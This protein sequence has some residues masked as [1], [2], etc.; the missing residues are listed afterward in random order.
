[1]YHTTGWLQYGIDPIYLKILSFMFTS[2][3]DSIQLDHTDKTGEVGGFVQ[4]T[5]LSQK[6]TV[7]QSLIYFTSKY[8]NCIRAIDRLRHSLVHISGVCGSMIQKRFNDRPAITS[9][10]NA[11]YFGPECEYRKNIP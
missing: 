5:V 11:T 8:G 7:N 4:S 10:S 3:V 9:V 2:Q 1:M 6:G